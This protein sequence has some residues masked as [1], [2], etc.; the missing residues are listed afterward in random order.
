IVSY[1][2]DDMGNVIEETVTDGITN[3]VTKFGY[4]QRGHQISVTD[5]RLKTTTYAFDELGRQVTTTGA[6]VSVERDGGA[7]TATK[8]TT[9]TG[10][11]TF[12]EVGAVADALGNVATAGY[13]R[14]GRVVSTTLP[15]HQA[16]TPTTRTS[17]DGNG[18]VTEVVNARGFSTKTS[19]DQLDRL[20]TVD[21]PATTG[22]A[23]SRFTYTRAGELLSTTAPDGA[24]T[25]S[26]YDD[27]DREIT[28]TQYERKPTT[29]TFTSW[30]R[31][32]DLGNVTSAVAPS[33]AAASFTYDTLGQL[34]KE[35]DP[36]GVPTHYGYDAAG[37]AVRV[38]D[39]IGR[40]TRL[41]YDL[42]GDQ[43]AQSQL[44][45]DGTVL[46][47]SKY[48]YDT[49]GNPTTFT[50]AKQNV[51]TLEFDAGNRLVKQVEPEGVTQEFG[52]D[53]AG[54]LTRNTDPRGNRTITTYNPWGLQE[55][56][57]EPATAAHPTDRTWTSEYDANGNE[58]KLTSPGGVERTRTFDPADQLT[59]ETGG[60]AEKPTTARDIAYD[61]VG[62]AKQIGSDTY[63]YDDRGN[64]LTTAGPGGAAEFGYDAD[65]NP[66]TRR[67]AAGTST[68]SYLKGR[69]NTVAEG[70][71]GVTQTFGYDGTGEVKTIGY[72]AGRAR[73]FGYDDYGRQ[74]SDVLT[75][76][77]GQTISSTTYG[78]DDTDLITSKTE[79]GVQTGYTYDALGRLKTAAAGGA[80]TAYEW[81]PAGNRTKA[82]AKT[83][84]YDERNR[85]LSDGDYTYSYSPR[86]TLAGRT[87]SGHTEPYAFDAFDRMVGAISQTYTYD[88]LD[89]VATRNGT[90]FTYAGQDDQVVSDGSAT[91]ARGPGD[92]L[93]ATKKG[94]TTRVPVANGHGDVIGAIAPDGQALADKTS[95]DAFGKVTA[96]TGDTGP[97]GYQGD[98]TDPATG[99]VDMGARWYEPTTGGFNARD[100]IPFQ[101]GEGVRAN[102]YTYGAADPVGQV[103]PDG[104]WPTPIVWPWLR[105]LVDG[106]DSD[107]VVSQSCVFS[108][109]GSNNS[110]WAL[111]QQANNLLGHPKEKSRGSSGTYPS[112]APGPAYN[113]SG[114]G[115]SCGACYNASAAARAEAAR[116]AE[117][118]R[119][120]RVTAQA[121]SAAQYS[122]RH[123]P[124]TVSS[125][126]HSPV[127]NMPQPVSSSAK[128]PAG[129]VGASR[130]VV[131]DT[132]RGTDKIY[133]Q[134]V[135]KAGNPVKN[136]SN[137]SQ[138]GSGSSS[139][140]SGWKWPGWK[141][142][143]KGLLSAAAEIS[144]FNDGKRCLMEGDLE[145]C[146][147]TVL[148]VASMFA[149]P[150]GVGAVR[151]AR[152]A[153]LGAKYG[154]DIVGAACA[155]IAGGGNSFA[156]DTRVRMGDGSTKAISSV[157]VGDE[158]TA[159]DPTTG[160]TGSYAVTDL[161]VGSGTKQ[162]TELTVS[163]EGRTSTLTTTD[164]HPFWA[165]GKWSEAGDLVAGQRVSEGEIVGTRSWTEQRTV[166]NL[167]VDTLHTFHVVTGDADVLV[168]NA[169]K[170]GKALAKVT[171]GV[172]KAGRGLA[173][174]ASAAGRGL[175]AA[176]RG[177]AK[178]ASAAGRGLAKGASA[179]GRP[180]AR[181]AESLGRG[182]YRAGVRSYLLVRKLG[183][184]LK[185]SG[186]RTAKYIRRNPL[187]F[188][189]KCVALP[190]VAVGSGVI[191]GSGALT[192]GALVAA[193]GVCAVNMTHDGTETYK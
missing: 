119:K 115:G 73:T 193:L 110:A 171:A 71:A 3:R 105:E 144:G 173:S 170:C 174:G 140:G 12:D 18:N 75:G 15:T 135:Q 33:G 44:K 86:G 96:K 20:V 129:T 120:T 7:P 48:G 52:Y 98:W 74:T 17:Y 49:A 113:G 191:T 39:S 34:I 118:E 37:N 190:T 134:A 82:G 81:D 93:L 36:A 182:A 77:T 32:D 2:H 151:G 145:S 58:V 65:G 5:P 6:E 127:T 156:G 24:R 128:L 181:G 14:L 22:R 148:T 35:T 177:L 125:E 90:A 117:Y 55:K 46:R 101:G 68:Y 184:E 172:S 8:P 94:D 95:Y 188:F 38:A 136:T 169:G 137:A 89:R 23:I 1:Q 122:A 72:G 142:F 79:N 104:H 27:L 60:G 150:L 109:L 153:R 166:Y 10:Y 108:C 162:M 139:G 56:T 158:V 123:V 155:V 83:S 57:I 152:G 42:F 43:V 141:K 97:L 130:D 50:D 45:P 66:T 147:W 161:I 26:T 85:L 11:N 80:T 53:A 133:D 102:R 106:P 183:R 69:L 149:G 114:G 78:H 154:D 165:D 47:T 179:V 168:H 107:W 63:T 31:Y 88:G 192:A 100:D 116:R 138:P 21:E 146:A 121:R 76:S 30:G 103:D 180:L 67:D 64:L 186:P 91:F 124:R 178:G 16:I 126:T 164:G 185:I 28:S 13:D 132:K 40:T 92:E 167:T 54:N 70:L 61:I 189:L 157:Q 143:G 41:V 111:Q 19:Y 51:T 160:Q 87:S 187:R 131:A 4:D 176:G 9:K 99:Q 29:G 84:T 163:F 159:A 112:Y 175:S 59:A 62:Q 25:E